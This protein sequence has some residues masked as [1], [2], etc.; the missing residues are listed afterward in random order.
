LLQADKSAEIAIKRQCLRA[1]RDPAPFTPESFGVQ[2][3]RLRCRRSPVVYRSPQPVPRDDGAFVAQ[4]TADGVEHAHGGGDGKSLAESAAVKLTARRPEIPGGG[5]RRKKDGAYPF[6][7]LPHASAGCFVWRGRRAIAGT[8]K[9]SRP[10]G[11]K[12]PNPRGSPA[13]SPDGRPF[14]PPPSWAAQTHR[15]SGPPRFSAKSP[16]C[17]GPT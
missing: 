1:T 4:K 11:G 10:G 5:P 14:P 7:S 6:A 15:T 3:G 13:K 16:F 8:A 17:V 12:K 2:D 9:G